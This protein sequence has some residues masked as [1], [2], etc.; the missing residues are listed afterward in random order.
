[1]CI[2]D[3][4]NIAPLK[5]IPLPIPE[6]MTSTII[7]NVNVTY[8]SLI[9]TSTYAEYNVDLHLQ[10]YFLEST[11]LQAMIIIQFKET[12]R[13]TFS[14]ASR[15]SESLCRTITKSSLSYRQTDRSCTG[16]LVPWFVCV[17]RAETRFSADEP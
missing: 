12:I 6:E 13:F 10:T 11:C 2:R 17:V 3:R 7:N 8:V 5:N 9:V 16:R 15:G 14:E 4:S 1:M